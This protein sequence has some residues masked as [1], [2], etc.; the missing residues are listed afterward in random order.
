MIYKAN[1][2]E[3][4]IKISASN[5]GKFRFKT[6]D[7]NISFGHT[8]STRNNNFTEKV[9]LEWQIGYDATVADVKNRNKKTNLKR[10]TFIGANGKK[11][12]L[13]E[14]SELVYE[15]LKNNL[16]SAKE[17]DDLL[18]EI[19][20]YRNFFDTNKIEIDRNSSITLNN[21]SFEETSI[22]LPTL[23][24]IDTSDGTQVEI[25]IQKQQYA[26]G[27]QPMVYFCIPLKSF[28]NYKDIMGRPSN[29]S[30]LLAYVINKENSKVLFDIIKI[31]AMCSARHNHDI[32]EIIKILI[33]LRRGN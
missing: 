19:K 15:G 7:N 22:K 21:I 16:I 1:S 20:S 13:Y 10:K 18:K 31:F 6:R 24:M 14:L 2:K 23:F 3:I 12:Y 28:D 26:S 27:V 25:S 32:K 29:S 17:I 5:H 9:Y 30:D 33:K 8:F 11:K 4:V